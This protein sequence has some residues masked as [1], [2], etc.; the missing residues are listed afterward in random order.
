M[1]KER[2][3]V[4]ETFKCYLSVKMPHWTQQKTLSTQSGSYGIHAYPK[5]E[6]QT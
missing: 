6:T 2:N 5:E 4:T 3:I 1:K